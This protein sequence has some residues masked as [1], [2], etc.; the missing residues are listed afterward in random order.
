MTESGA[1][2]ADC[3]ACAWTLE[4]TLD[5]GDLSATDNREIGARVARSHSFRCQHDGSEGWGETTDVDVWLAMDG[6]GGDGA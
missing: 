1:F 3:A 5:A 6:V 2:H 4:R